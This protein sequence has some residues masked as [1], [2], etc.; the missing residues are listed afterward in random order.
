MGVVYPK[1]AAGLRRLRPEAVKAI[2]T[3]ERFVGL[4]P[5]LSRGRILAAF[6]RAAPCL[7][8]APRLRDA[9]DTLMAYSQPQD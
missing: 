7:G 5:N 6:K 9:V 4:P 2:A 3:A 1:F 8:I